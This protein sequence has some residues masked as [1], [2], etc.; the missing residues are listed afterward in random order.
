[1]N[2]DLQETLAA[3]LLDLA[4]AVRITSPHSYLLLGEERVFPEQE[5]AAGEPPPMLQTLE[6]EIYLHL[7]TRLRRLSPAAAGAGVDPL[8]SRDLVNALSAANQGTGTWESGWRIVSS[9]EDGTRAVARD[10]V[11]FWVQPAGLR[12]AGGRQDPGDYCRV[13]VGKELRNLIPGFYVAIGNGEAADADR[14][15]PL[16]RL[17]WHL[18]AEAAVP[19]M[20]AM[21]SALNALGV[22]FRT[23][24]LADPAAYVR[25]DA[26]VL[27][28]ERRLFG[29]LRPVLREIHGALAGA[30]RPEVPMFT[31]P[32]APGLGAAEDP[33]NGMSFGQARCRTAS[34]ALWTA[35]AEKGEEVEVRA[36]ALAEAFSREE[37]D[38]AN[39]HL[40]PGSKA[41]Y[42]LEEKQRPARKRKRR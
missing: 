4:A 27:Y 8:G 28:V 12:T 39:L 42:D 19:Y 35:F 6:T 18:T 13:R 5:I 11:T 40:A 15:G 3:D 20:A 23:K 37:L 29:R 17:Y 7:Y 36:A 22:P 33:G 41:V 34:R 21:T 24:V 38:V 9:E 2:V 14:P 32:L 25:A 26:G 1:M 10:G 16:L 31:R 30:L